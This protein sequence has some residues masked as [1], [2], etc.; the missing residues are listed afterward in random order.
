MH[1]TNYEDFSK[2]AYYALYN[3][4][5]EYTIIATGSEV[6]LAIEVSKKLQ[7]ENISLN[8]VSM[9]MM[10]VFDRQDEEYKNYILKSGHDKTITLEMLSSYGW[11]K[12]GKYNFG[13]DTF[14]RS[15]KASDVIKYFGFDVDSMCEKIKNL[16]K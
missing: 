6:D 14:G 13:I 16:I 3:D 5:S 10:D 11:G 4:N 8:V 2:G 1:K 7:E 9:P 12:Y 15:A